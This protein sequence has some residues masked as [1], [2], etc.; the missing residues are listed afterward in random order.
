MEGHE[1][2]NILLEY[3]EEHAK[4]FSNIE[5]ENKLELAD[6]VYVSHIKCKAIKEALKK[7]VE[8]IE[9]DSL[10]RDAINRIESHFTALESKRLW[11]RRLNI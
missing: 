1:V 5:T 9:D 3:H 4:V 6:M 2:I 8:S 11:G 10:K 7:V